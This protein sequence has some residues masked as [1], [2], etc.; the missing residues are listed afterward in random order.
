MNGLALRSGLPVSRQW[1]GIMPRQRSR[2]ERHLLPQS[3]VALDADCWGDNSFGQST[4]ATGT[5]TQ[6]SA[7][8]NHT[9][10]LRAGGF[11]NCWGELVT[12]DP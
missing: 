4:P 8:E 10:G 6:I 12:P 9:C 3:C 5:F 7:G 1:G 11:A 2:C